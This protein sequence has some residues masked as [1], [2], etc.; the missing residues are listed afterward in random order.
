MPFE[1]V[2]EIYSPTDHAFLVPMGFRQMNG[3]R[4]EK[5]QA[6]K[7]SG[8]RLISYVSSKSAVAE[9]VVVGE[10]VMIY[11]GAVVEAYSRIGDNVIIRS[12]AH[13]SHHCRIRNSCFLAAHSVLGGGV[14]A[15]D[16][17]FIGLNAT[18]RDNVSIGRGAAVGAGSL[19]LKDAEAHSLYYGVPAEKHDR[20]PIEVIV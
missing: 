4:K 6:V 5:Y 14:N 3:L 16:G 19:L 12:G 7:R 11:E 17:C 1:D 9:G 18:V 10:N 2:T 20:P 15:A 8:Y 13:V